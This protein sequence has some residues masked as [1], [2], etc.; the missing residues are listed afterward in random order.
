M[1]LLSARG[2]RWFGSSVVAESCY[3]YCYRVVS[4][5]DVSWDRRPATT[6]WHSTPA[7][8]EAQAGVTAD[9]RAMI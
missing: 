7:T 8:E 1:M 6:S 4:G 3:H 5:S 9:R 2:V